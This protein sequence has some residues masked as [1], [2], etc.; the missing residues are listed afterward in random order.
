M[1]LKDEDNFSLGIAHHIEQKALRLGK[2]RKYFFTQWFT[3]R[4]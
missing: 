4:F 1:I 3:N 2:P